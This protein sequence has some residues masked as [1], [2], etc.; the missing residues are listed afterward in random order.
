M[1]HLV[2]TE[3]FH[4]DGQRV[5]ENPID[6]TKW[7]ARTSGAD[8]LQLINNVICSTKVAFGDGSALYIPSLPNDQY[9]EVI[10]NNPP[11]TVDGDII[12][13]ELR[14]GPGTPTIP[15]LPQWS[16]VVGTNSDGTGSYWFGQ[17]NAA[18][19][20]Y[21]YFDAIVSNTTPWVKGDRLTVSIVGTFSTGNIYF[22][23]NGIILLTVPLNVSVPFVAGGR[24]SLQTGPVASGSI[25]RWAVG[26]V[27]LS[28]SPYDPHFAP[29]YFI[30]NY[31][32]GFI[33][34][35]AN[36]LAE[37]LGGDI[38]FTKTFSTFVIKNPGRVS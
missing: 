28:S 26:S 5:N 25:S 13:L 15:M 9:C 32:D 34:N 10:I 38:A 35:G 31:P 21:T 4:D 27:S 8:R 18:G 36:E 12:A 11:N 20:A 14:T 17:I 33:A 19:S 7:Q 24:A 22:S 30:D 16:A 23:R 2:F 29:K 37:V 6:P 3:L 1:S